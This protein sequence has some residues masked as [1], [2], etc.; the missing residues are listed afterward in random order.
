ME[1]SLSLLN[2]LASGY[3]SGK[4]LLKLDS[5]SMAM[6]HHTADH[7]AFLREPA[8]A[9][10]RTAFYATLG[11]LLFTE[12]STVKFKAFVQPFDQLSQQLTQL[13][14]QNPAAFRSQPTR[15]LLSGLFRDLRGVV[16]ATASRRT[17]CMFF[18]WVYPQHMPLWLAA[19]ETFADSPDVADP[20]LKLL[21]ELVQNR[22]Q[23][24]T[25]E[26]SS[27]SGILLFRELSRLVCAYGQRILAQPVPASDPYAT[28]YKG[29]AAAHCALQRA[30]AGNYVNFGVF[31][32]Y[33]DRA[34]S[35]VLDCAL[36]LAVSTP[37]D[38]LLGFRK[39]RAGRG[40]SVLRCVCSVRGCV[41]AHVPFLV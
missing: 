10:S 35:E 13:F 1:A 15:A 12:D 6:Q 27:V 37:L 26:P 41:F 39:A 18:D 29:V 30:L 3:M 11:R 24:I 5:V 2:E 4:L 21:A 40:K 7:F 23:R 19:M 38:D 20:L 31:D 9:R 32:L 22:T 33:G 36:L 8:N 28:R 34:L 17:Y 25:F 14:Q 16:S